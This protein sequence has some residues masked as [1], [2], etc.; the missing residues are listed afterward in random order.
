MF[1]YKGDVQ[2]ASKAANVSKTNKINGLEVATSVEEVS[3][4]ASKCPLTR[5]WAH[6]RPLTA[7]NL[8]GPGL[9]MTTPQTV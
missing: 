2:K 6:L 4:K 1:F 3:T 8:L 7:P 9:A 5:G